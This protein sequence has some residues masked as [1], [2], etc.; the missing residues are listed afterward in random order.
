MQKPLVS[1]NIKDYGTLNLNRAII[2]PAEG[3]KQTWSPDGE[4]HPRVS[5]I[6][7]KVVPSLTQLLLTSAL[8]IQT[9]IA[10][11]ITNYMGL[12][13]STS[14]K[15]SQSQLGHNLKQS[16]DI[17]CTAKVIVSPASVKRTKQEVEA[18]VV[19]DKG[20]GQEEEAKGGYVEHCSFGE[21]VYYGWSLRHKYTSLLCTRSTWHRNCALSDKIS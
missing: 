18:S 8:N 5:P 20:A 3:R 10:K 7:G 9:T 17:E 19:D 4:G 16:K 6:F 15:R 1:Y 13:D 21:I 12:D 11:E 2:G 14:Q